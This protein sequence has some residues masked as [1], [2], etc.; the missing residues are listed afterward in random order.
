MLLYVGN[1]GTPGC[2]ASKML[3]SVAVCSTH[4]EVVF[5][6]FIDCSCLIAHLS[7]AALLV[8][9]SVSATACR[10]V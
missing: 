7:C 8:G 5:M 1:R 3:H 2:G 9:Y 6:V 10:N 4:V